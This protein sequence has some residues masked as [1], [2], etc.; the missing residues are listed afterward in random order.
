MLVNKSSLIKTLTK[1]SLTTCCLIAVCVSTGCR[2]NSRADHGAAAG[3]IGGAI[4]GGIV[5]KQ[6]GNTGAGAA[7]GGITGLIAGGSIGQELDDIEARNQAQIEAQLGRQLV[8]GA[9]PI[10]DVMEMS[11]NGVPDKLIINHINTN[12]F[13]GTLTAQDL[14]MLNQQGVS[15]DVVTAMQTPIAPKVQRVVPAS[16][17]MVIE[18]H[19]YPSPYC[20]RPHR[21][22]HYHHPRK[23]SVGISFHGH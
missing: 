15:S 8:A 22:R 11:K 23:S 14:I 16:R 9:V 3:G 17:P 2:S 12:G 13:R 7:I 10:E 4:L 20:H 18:E 6:L 19:Y 1:I 5:G 21:H